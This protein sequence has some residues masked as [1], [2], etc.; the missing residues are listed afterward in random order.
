M[1][2]HLRKGI[3]QPSAHAGRHATT[4]TWRHRYV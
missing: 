3:P 2:V 1:Y 4:N